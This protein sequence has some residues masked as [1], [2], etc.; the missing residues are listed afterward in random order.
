VGAGRL[1]TEAS[2]E[3]GL[4]SADDYDLVAAFFR[5]HPDLAPTPLR[6]LPALAHSLGLGSLLVKDET[7]RFGLNAFKLLGARFA[8]E[9]LLAEGAIRP[10]DTLVCASEGNHGRAVAHSARALGCRARVYL[11]ESVAH[12]RSDAIAGENAAVVR[13]PGTY[14]DAVRVAAA[15]AATHGWT[16]VSDTSWPGYDHV[17]R[18]IMLGYTRMMDEMVEA[19]PQG[20]RPDTV[21]VPGG[22]GGLLAAVASWVARHWASGTQVLAVEP[23]GAA[24]LQASAH[25][26]RP[27]VVP[28]PFDS[29]MGGLRCG[30]VS[31]L[32]FEAALP[33]V[34]AYVG[35]GDDWAARAMRTLA[36]PSGTDPRIVAGPSG[37]AALGGLLAA[38]EDPAAMNVRR[39]LRLGPA[40]TVVLIATEGMTDPPLWHRIVGGD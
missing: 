37:A 17:P 31:P 20:W 6:A 23:V 32:A 27:A 11:S 10:G 14:D 2:D 7:A 4:F 15:D 24:C 30:E 28:G 38:L 16:V 26:G 3:P 8:V 39:V 21:I 25:A 18:L 5:S 19:M 9:R 22:V 12:A 36:R 13:V 34:S 33:L 35:I 40:S 29:M 1:A